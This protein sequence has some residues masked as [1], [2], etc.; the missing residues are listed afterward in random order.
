MNRMTKL[1][2]A[3]KILALLHSNNAIPFPHVAEK[4][5]VNALANNACQGDSLCETFIR[6]VLKWAE[7]DMRK[8]CDGPK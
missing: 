6:N 8:N 3:G 7:E 5:S 1:R 4:P 2:K